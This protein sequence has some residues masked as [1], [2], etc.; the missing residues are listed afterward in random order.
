MRNTKL[1]LVPFPKITVAHCTDDVGHLEGG[2]GSLLDLPPWVSPPRQG[3]GDFDGFQ[4]GWQLPADGGRTNAGRGGIIILAWPT[5]QM[6]RGRH[7]FQHVSPRELWRRMRTAALIP[8]R[9][10]ATRSRPSTRPFEVMGTSARQLF[11]VA[12]ERIGSLEL[13]PAPV[14]TPKCPTAL[15]SIEHRESP[16]ARACPCGYE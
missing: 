9:L 8:A 6:V 13:H 10:P 16:S 12:W 15:G 7:G 11:T 2:A 4:P 3:P 14:L 5:G 1:R